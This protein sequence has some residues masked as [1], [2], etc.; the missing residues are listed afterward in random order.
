MEKV[1]RC[2]CGFE[3]R[4]DDDEA[5]V[6]RA[7]DHARNAHGIEFTTEQLLQLTARAES[8]DGRDVHRTTKGDRT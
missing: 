5:L 2:D 1:L 8:R 7:R 3:V 6:R 4:A